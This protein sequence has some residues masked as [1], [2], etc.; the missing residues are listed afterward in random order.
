MSIYENKKYLSEN[1]SWHVEDSPWKAAQVLKI[2]K[3]NKIISGKNTI[4]EVG[5]GAGEIIVQLSSLLSEDILFTGYDISSQL[6]EF[7]KE[8]E[9]SRIHFKQQDF[10]QTK[11]TYDVLLLI[12]IVEH[13]E[14][15]IGFIRKIKERAVY[16][17]FNFPLE[18]FALKA[19]FGNKFLDSREKYGHIHYFNKDI[20][21]AILKELDFEIIDF[22][23]APRAI[24]LSSTTSSISPLSRMGKLPRVL[25][26][27]ISV[28]FTAKLLGGY[29]FFILAK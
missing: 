10:L 5:C 21:L 11:E 6:G 24:D 3:K 15:Y 1:E 12:D 19:L 17:V 22:F 2:F 26:S 8:R 14:D 27:K 4:C 29:S 16:K 18:I 28:D 23:Y 20:C 9:N 7:W 25:L 13:I